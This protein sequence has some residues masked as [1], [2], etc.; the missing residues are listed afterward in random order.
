MTTRLALTVCQ[1]YASAILWRD[2]AG[3][4]L[5]TIENRTWPTDYRGPLLIHAG[6]SRAWLDDYESGQ[7]EVL[8]VQ[9]PYCNDLPFGAIIGQVNLVDSLPLADA[10]AIDPTFAF[11]PFCF[12]LDDPITFPHPIP[13]R[14]QL[15]FFRVPNA[16]LGPQYAL[17]HPSPVSTPAPPQAAP[18][19]VPVPVRPCSSTPTQ[20]DLF[21]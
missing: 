16:V 9:Y 7:F 12:V 1:P 15:G 8:R 17:H 21:S 4:R 6:K 14:G 3:H 20:L 19:S 13:Y 10:R 11:G 5:K 18:L 2:P